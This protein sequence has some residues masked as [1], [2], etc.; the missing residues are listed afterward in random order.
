MIGEPPHCDAGPTY[1]PESPWA[2]SERATHVPAPATARSWSTGGEAAV[3]QGAQDMPCSPAIRGWTPK[4]L[5][6]NRTLFNNP[7]QSS[8]TK[9]GNLTP[10]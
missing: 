8:A 7:R 10:P 4:R 3:E 5:S 2:E 1:T 6:P 9:P